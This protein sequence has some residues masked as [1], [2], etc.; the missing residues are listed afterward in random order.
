MPLP[1]N[2]TP[3]KPNPSIV[4]FP[5]SSLFLLPS[6]SPVMTERSKYIAQCRS[7]SSPPTRAAAY[8]V[9]SATHHT[10]PILRQERRPLPPTDL[11][12]LQSRPPLESFHFGRSFWRRRR[13]F[14]QALCRGW[15]ACSARSGAQS[16][17]RS[18]G[19][20]RGGIRHCRCSRCRWCFPLQCIFDGG[21]LIIFQRSEEEWFATS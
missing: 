10:F 20:G 11:R 6:P 15:T 8:A 5:S 13:R 19:A 7:R 18:S 16:S 2:P 3:S 4:L 17:R 1:T 9:R 14:C 12:P 21:I